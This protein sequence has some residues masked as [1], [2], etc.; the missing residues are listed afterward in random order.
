MVD[1]AAASD[2]LLFCN[3]D[4]H[5]ALADFIPFL[6]ALPALERP[7]Y[8]FSPPLFTFAD[9]VLISVQAK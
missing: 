3:T 8:T 5:F 2:Y 6:V 7:A 1:A 9:F 4:E